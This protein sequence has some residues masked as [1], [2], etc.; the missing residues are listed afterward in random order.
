[1]EEYEICRN[2]GSE[3]LKEHCVAE[4]SGLPKLEGYDVCVKKYA[5]GAKTY[6]LLDP[7]KNIVAE[8]WGLEEMAVEIETARM[9]KESM[10]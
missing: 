8:E 9:I 5:D 7:E 3:S 6:I 1:M 10:Q 2:D 4:C